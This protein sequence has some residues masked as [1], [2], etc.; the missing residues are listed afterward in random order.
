MLR[1][2]SLI[3]LASAATP[4]L[5]I[6]DAKVSRIDA[7]TVLVRWKNAAPVDVLISDTPSLPSK[8]KPVSAKN[9]TGEARI[10]LSAAKRQYAVLRD[11]KSKSYVIVAERELP[12]AKG[13]NFRDLGGYVG[14]G[15]RK[16]KW[17]KIFRSG[18]LP[19]LNEGDYQ[20][21]GGLGIKTIVDLRSTDER[22]VAPTQLDDRT[23]ALFIS[24]DY[25]LRPLMQ[26][27]TASSGE[28]MYKGMETLLAPQ[29]RSV[30]R[31]LLA[32]DG[33]VM[34]NCSA[35]Q[36]RT[37]IT[38]AL[39]LTAL[40]VDRKTILEDYHLSTAL[41]RPQNEMPPVDP[42]DYPGN[43]IVQYYAAAAK[44]PGGAKAEPLYSPKGTSHL[45]QFFEMV[46]KDYGGVPRY[47]ET[48]LGITPSDVARLKLLYLQ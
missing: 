11:T 45:I 2:A 5:A 15:G 46:D 25:S 38:T 17:G 19:M 47:L 10:P 12:L 36:D 41:R 4:A 24:N 3:L 39:V 23:G 48:V 37:G 16:V 14:A 40:G 21:L 26:R 30:F 44:K 13:S 33:A 27:T 42:A 8:T 20:L 1:Y 34:Y 31:R 35:G 32:D 29:F 9:G 7:D 18:A 43:L 6:D 28:N 22:Q